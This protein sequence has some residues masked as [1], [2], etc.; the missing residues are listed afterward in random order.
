MERFQTPHPFALVGLLVDGHRL[1][2]EPGD[3]TLLEL[4][5]DG[6][7]AFEKVIAPFCRRLDFDETTTILP[8]RTRKRR[9]DRPASCVREASHQRH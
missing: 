6:Q 1:L 5:S 2:K 3:E 8:R 7:T 9:S 4:G